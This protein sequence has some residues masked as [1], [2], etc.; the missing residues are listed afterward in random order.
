MHRRGSDGSRS[1]QPLPIGVQLQVL[2]DD[3]TSHLQIPRVREVLEAGF[4]GDFSDADWAHTLGGW[5]VVALVDDAPVSH[6]AVVPRTITVADNP[7]R[8][9]YVEGVVTRPDRHGEGL[10][11]LVMEEVTRLIAGDFELGALST[12]L[13]DFYR[14]FGWEPW[15]GQSYVCDGERLV[16]TADEDDGIMVLRWG[17]SLGISLDGSIACDRRSGDDW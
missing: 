7:F 17:P 14:R 16:R 2:R 15:L 9:G 3:E 6:A 5:R 12:A 1:G 4:K 10:G 13:T 11:S 8:A